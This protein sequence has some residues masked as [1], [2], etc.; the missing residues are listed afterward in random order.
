MLTLVGGYYAVDI[1]VQR[2]RTRAMMSAALEATSDGLALSDLSQRQLQIL[3]AVEDPGFY[4]HHGIDFDTPGG[5]LT[6]I[7]QSLGKLHY[8][9]RFE[10]GVRKIRLCLLARFALDPILS[11]DDQL[12][13]FINE[14]GLRLV[15]GRYVRGFA[16]GARAHYG[17]SFAELDEQKR[18]LA[19]HD[20]AR[21]APP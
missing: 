2:S 11:K 15:D 9:E 13:L 5:G 18:V 16:E 19:P 10:P 3:L 21:Q 7:T 14:I 20:P 17:K 1:L 12:T 8:F 4:E 6:T